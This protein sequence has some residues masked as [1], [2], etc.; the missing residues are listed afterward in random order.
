[1]VRNIIFDLDGTLIDSV[2]DIINCL[3]KSFSENNI[4]YMIQ[5]ERVLIGPSLSDMIDMVS[6]NLSNC[7]KEKLINKFKKFYDNSDYENTSLIRG[8]REL[9]D[10]LKEMKINI[11]IST[12]KR[13]VPTKRILKK[14][15]MESYLK[16]AFTIDFNNGKLMGKT[17]VTKYIIN[18]FKFKRNQTICVG[19]T[20]SDIIAASKN[21]LRSVIFLNGYGNREDIFKSKPTY[22]INKMLDLITVVNKING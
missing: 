22:T 3:K 12:S 9:L 5:D 10:E 6:P 11:Y 20:E 17:E 1:M 16:G 2:K 8:V 21:G 18:K 4:K 15:N 14:L 13:L 19:D 7:Q